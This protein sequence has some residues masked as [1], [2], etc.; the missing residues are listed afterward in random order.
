MGSSFSL[1]LL[2]VF[3]NARRTKEHRVPGSA[4]VM[5][6]AYVGTRREP[7]TWTKSRRE[8]AIDVQRR[9]LNHCQGSGPRTARD[10]Q[11]R[12]QKITTNPEK[13]TH[14]LRNNLKPRMVRWSL[15]DSSRMSKAV[16]GKAN[17]NTAWQQ[18]SMKMVN[19][20][21]PVYPSRPI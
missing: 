17:V 3:Y 11:I 2:R 19:R 16:P 9:L 1:G 7:E 5:K 8:F 10:C 21:L 14:I 18:I 20:G 13:G 4:S 6:G 15:T 12:E